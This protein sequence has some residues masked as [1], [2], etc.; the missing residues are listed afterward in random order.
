MGKWGVWVFCYY[1]SRYSE[2]WSGARRNSADVLNTFARH[3]QFTYKH[4]LRIMTSLRMIIDNSQ[5]VFIHEEDERIAQVLV[6][7]CENGHLFFENLFIWFDDTHC[8]LETYIDSMQ[9]R[10]TW[11]NLYRSLL[12]QLSR[13]KLFSSFDDPDNKLVQEQKSSNHMER[14]LG[15]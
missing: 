6:S 7:L 5:T 2:S 10:I 11:K 4:T 1:Y 9:R 8:N 12:V 3:P 15:G 14:D 13:K